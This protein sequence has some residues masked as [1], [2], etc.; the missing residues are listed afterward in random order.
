MWDDA[1]DLGK[2]PHGCTTQFVAGESP[3]GDKDELLAMSDEAKL[4]GH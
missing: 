1:M 3:V 2:R 4:V